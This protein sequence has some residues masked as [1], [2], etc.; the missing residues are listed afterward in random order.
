[1]KRPVGSLLLVALEVFY[2]LLG[3]VSG[4]LLISDPSGASLGFTSEVLD[5][6]PFH[7]FLPVGL[8]L[9]FV[10]GAVPMVLAYGAAT[11]KELIFGKISQAGRHHWS[12]TGGMPL[13]VVLVIWLIVEG[14][15]IGLNYAATYFTTIIG[16][17]IFIMLIL[18]STRKFY[19]ARAV[20]QF[21]EQA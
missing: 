6:I 11:R 12:W 3:L 19:R 7:S 2:G 8:F 16:A 20:E 1:M 17:A 4:S 15:L 14:S 21:N 9:F 13:M 18:P 10:Y 5:K